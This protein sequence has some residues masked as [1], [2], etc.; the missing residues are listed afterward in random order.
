MARKSRAKEP[1]SLTVHGVEE[2]ME[3]ALRVQGNWDMQDYLRV[4]RGTTWK[5]SPCQSLPGLTQCFELFK[6]LLLVSPAGVTGRHVEEFED[7]YE[8]RCSKL[9]YRISLV[10][11]I[12]LEKSR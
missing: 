6:E 1:A 9:F 7:K 3:K 5:T 8:I 11:K 12:V 2:A 10:Y 4:F